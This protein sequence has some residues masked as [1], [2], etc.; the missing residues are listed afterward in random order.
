MFLE[1]HYYYENDNATPTK[2]YL[3]CQDFNTALA[4]T[5]NLRNQ[6]RYVGNFI[7]NADTEE[8]S[9]YKDIFVRDKDNEQETSDITDNIVKNADF[10]NWQTNWEA[11]ESGGRN[12]TATTNT[13]VVRDDITF[14]R[15]V[16][17]DVAGSGGYTFSQLVSVKPYCYY[18]LKGVGSYIFRQCRR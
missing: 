5:D 7:Y 3:G 10:E 4:D 15:C 6:W 13:D 9:S 16:K 2:I 12:L 1:Q 18:T 17:F 14:T 11:I 8:T